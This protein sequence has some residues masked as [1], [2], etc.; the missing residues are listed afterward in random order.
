MVKKSDVFKMDIDMSGLE[1]LTRS[2]KQ[3]NSRHIRFG[4]LNGKNYPAGHR[5]AGKSIAW[6]ASLQEFGYQ[7]DSAN[8][9]SRPYFRQTINKIRYAYYERLKKVFLSSLNGLT[10][11]MELNNLAEEFK[12]D[13]YEQVAKQNHKSLSEYTIKIKGHRYQMGHT[14]VM[15]TN[16]ESK[17][18]KQ[19]INTIKE[20]MKEK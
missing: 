9:P 11:N 12:K 7:G 14:G 16:F 5:N 2:C 15:L 3:L 8:I 20:P 1:R 6:I 4:W 19:S 13:Y 17:V 10:D 18:Y